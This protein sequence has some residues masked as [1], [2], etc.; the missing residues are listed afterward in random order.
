L[1]PHSYAHF[2]FDKVT[3]N[4]WWRKDSLFNKCCWEKWLSVCRKLKLDPCLSP[5]TFNNSEWIKNLIIR[6]ETL[7]LVQER[8]GNILEAKGSKGF[9]SRTLL[10]QQLRER[11][12]TWDYI[13]LKSFVNKRNDQNTWKNAHI[14]GHKGNANQ[15][16][17]KI[18]PHPC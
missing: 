4:I 7:Q 5:C 1:N 6:P 12:D 15:D 14:F 11:M 8:E 3:K 2:I 16:H 10:A 9:C 13:K 18:P 17:T